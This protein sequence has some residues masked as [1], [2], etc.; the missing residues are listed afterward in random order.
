[1][2]AMEWNVDVYLFTTF[3]LYEKVVNK[4]INLQLIIIF[5]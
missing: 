4:K 1:M 5:Q 2:A 3:Q